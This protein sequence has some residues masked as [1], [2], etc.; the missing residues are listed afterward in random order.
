MA[1]EQA[2]NITYRGS[3]H[4]GAFVFEIAIPEIKSVRTVKGSIEDLT[5]YTFSK[6]KLHHKF[7][8]QCGTAIMITMPNGPPNSNFCLN[9]R[10]IQGLDAWSLERQLIDGASLG[11]KYEASL[12]SGA[13][14]P[15]QINGGN[16]YNGSCHCGAVQVALASKPIDG[17]FPDTIGECNCSI[18]IRNA[19]IWVW[20]HRD[21]VVLHNDS[22]DIGCYFFQGSTL[23]AKTFCKMCGVQ[24]TNKPV[25]QS[26]EAIAAMSD[27]DRKLYDMISPLHPVNLRVFDGIDLNEI[28]GKVEKLPGADR[29][30]KYVNP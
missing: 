10:S 19:Y 14:P 11:D 22:N 23:L 3:C 21:H 18:C 30:P 28:V 7:C 2:P 24:L 1:E 8:P 15:E 25:L 17:T 26:D 16:V 5:N 6:G 13:Q 27:G 4:C 29:P 12:Y 20:P 9:A